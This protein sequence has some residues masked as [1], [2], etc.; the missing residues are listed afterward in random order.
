MQ[1]SP[2][3]LLLLKSCYRLC[4]LG[5]IWGGLKL[6]LLCIKRGSAENCMVVCYN[7]AWLGMGA[8][9]RRSKTGS[10]HNSSDILNW[11]VS[12]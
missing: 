7:Y 4:I 1:V 6:A 10:H 11:R 2:S 8:T 9:Y 5:Q 3:S 12:F